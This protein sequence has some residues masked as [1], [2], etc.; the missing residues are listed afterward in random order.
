MHRRL[1]D[2][3]SIHEVF[4]RHT[5]HLFDQPLN[6]HLLRACLVTET[7]IWDPAHVGIVSPI[8]GHRA[9]PHHLT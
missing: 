5:R 9:S 3:K 1:L 7:S 6:P 4:C 8:Q 2:A